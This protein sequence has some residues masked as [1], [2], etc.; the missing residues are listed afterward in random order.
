MIALSALAVQATD[1]EEIVLAN[2]VVARIRTGGEHGNVSARAGKI[3]QRLVQALSYEDCVNPQMS[4]VDVNGRW[5]ISVGSTMLIQVYPEDVAA[6]GLTDTALAM[7]WKDNLA[8][9]LPL[10]V[11]PVKLGGADV[12]GEDPVALP[13]EPRP[14]GVPAEDLPLVAQM[15]GLFDRARQLDD[16]QYDLQRPELEASVLSMIW[17]YRRGPHCG[18]PPVTRDPRVGNALRLVRLVL[19]ERYRIERDMVAGTTIKRVRKKYDIPPGTGPVTPSE[20]LGPLPLPKPH[21]QSGTPIVQAVLGTGLDA[22]DKLQT[23]GQQFP[24]DTPQVMLYLQVK[25]ALNNTIVGVSMYAGKEI[26]GRR[27]FQVSGDRTVAISFYP[28]RSETFAAGDYECRL[29]VAD[30]PVGVIP[31][32]VGA[33]L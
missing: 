18:P 22:N 3:N 29:S 24:A 27:R 13:S 12:P 21:I 2:K 28:Q 25:G 1:Y 5:T 32:R 17:S 23:P 26:L 19:D 6:A 14:A 31:F 9:Q 11:S 30:Q 4:A 15:V 10:A 7:Q 20:P 16:A 33:P 8:A